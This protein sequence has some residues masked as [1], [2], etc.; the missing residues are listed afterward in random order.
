MNKYEVKY[1]VTSLI[2]ISEGDWK[3]LV[4]ESYSLKEES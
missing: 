4:G 2:Q 3:E 1:K